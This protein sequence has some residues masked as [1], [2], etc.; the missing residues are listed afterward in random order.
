M[1][2]NIIKNILNARFINEESTPGID[3]TK[4]VQK[5]LKRLI[6]LVLVTWLKVI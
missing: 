2:K 5:L 3:V 6:K 4:K 1:D